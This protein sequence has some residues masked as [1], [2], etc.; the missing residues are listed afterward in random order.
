MTQNSEYP[1]QPLTFSQREGEASLPET[2]KAK[3]LSRLFRQLILQRVEGEIRA[4]TRGQYARPYPQTRIGEIINN[5]RFYI[6]GKF[7]H[8]ISQDSW[9]NIMGVRI[10]IMNGTY[11]EVLTFVE[12]IVRHKLCPLS[13]RQALY[14]AFEQGKIAY[15]IEDLSGVPTVVPRVS[16]ESGA[17]TRRAIDTLREAGLDPATGHLRKAAEHINAERFA[18]SV[19][20]SIS[21]VESAAR[22]I[23]PG[24][25]TLG[26]ALNE[27]EKRGLIDNSQLKAGFEKVYAYTNSEEGIRHAQV[28][29]ESSNVGMDEAMFMFGACAAFA[30]F[31]VSKHRAMQESED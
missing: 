13:L 8:E 14:D 26:V 19:H 11:H 12:F 27:L 20:N 28:F 23:A 5:Y 25:K 22:H 18:E 9:Q 6:R 10:F 21:A 7:F 1:I 3:S 30:A 17:A 15:V 2:M 4:A 16:A 31:L 29:K 24:S